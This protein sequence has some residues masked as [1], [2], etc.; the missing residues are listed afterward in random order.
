MVL[1]RC[2]AALLTTGVVATSCGTQRHVDLVDPPVAE[3]GRFAFAIETRDGVRMKGVLDVSVD[4]IVARSESAPCR[5]MA[6]HSTG[7]AITYECGVPGTPGLRLLLDRRHPVRRSSWSL[8]TPVRKKRDVCVAY[9]TWEN[10]TQTCTRSVPE[11]YIE[12]VRVTGE[13]VVTR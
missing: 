10:G 12:Q 11:E 9:R 4:T 13:L 7:T 3:L 8:M 5:L 6:E 1:W 2:A